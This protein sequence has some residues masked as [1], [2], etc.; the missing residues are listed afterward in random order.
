MVLLLLN[1]TVTWHVSYHRGLYSLIRQRLTGIGIPII[2]LRRS[3]NRLRFIMGI[4]MPIKQWSSSIKASL[5]RLTT[6]KT[7]MTWS[8]APF[9]KGVLLW[10]SVDSPNGQRADINPC[11]SN[12]AHLFYDKYCSGKNS[13]KLWWVNNNFRNRNPIGLSFITLKYEGLGIMGWW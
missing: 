8:I 11:Y 7:L 9:G 5:F 3:D 6:T 12:I 13:R 4:L 2:D 1:I 10:W